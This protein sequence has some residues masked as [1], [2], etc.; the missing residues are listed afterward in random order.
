MGTRAA[1]PD[2][3]RPETPFPRSGQRPP[4]G[5]TRPEWPEDRIAGRPETRP[6]LGKNPPAPL[7]QRPSQNGKSSPLPPTHTC[8]RVPTWSPRCAA[9][10]PSRSRNCP[11]CRCRRRARRRPCPANSS[12]W[13]PA[14]PG[15]EAGVCQRPFLTLR[16]PDPLKGLDAKPTVHPQASAVP[17]PCVPSPH[18]LQALLPSPG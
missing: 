17:T 10:A 1:V 16:Q 15:W 12:P 7:G 8:G 13:G 14:T 11:G 2:T 3:P 6:G 18:K 9:V 4:S 5:N